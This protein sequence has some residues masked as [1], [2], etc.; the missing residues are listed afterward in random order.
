MSA[1]YSGSTTSRNASLL[2]HD[3]VTHFTY[4]KITSYTW[5]SHVTHMNESRC[6]DGSAMSQLT[7]PMQCDS[8]TRVTWLIHMCDVTR[9]HVWCGLFTRGMWRIHMWD[10]RHSVTLFILSSRHPQ[11]THHMQRDSIICVAWLVH[12]CHM[13][14]SRVRCD[15]FTCETW[16]I[17]WRCSS[18]V[19]GTHVWPITCNV[20]HS[21]VWRDSF[22]CVTWLIHAWDVTHSYV[23]RDAFRDVVDSE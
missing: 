3:C 7:H 5:M 16:R 17:P 18:R 10:V 23:T 11:L 21:Y 14:Y 13:A 2:T 6:T 8:I 1:Y 19:V 20:T 22:T 9:S 12:M 4:E 15:A